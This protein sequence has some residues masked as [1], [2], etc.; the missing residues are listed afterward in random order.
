MFKKILYPT[1]FSDVA[2]EAV[3]YID[4]LRDRD[5]QEVFI[6]HAIDSRILDLL[7]YNPMVSMEMERNLREDA[8]RSMDPLRIHFEEIGFLVS[9]GIEV[10]IPASVILRAE[11]RED[12]SIT[13]MGSH[14]KS[15]VREM[16]LGSVSEEVVRSSRKPVLI[17]KR[18]SR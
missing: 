6:I 9:L 7:V 8:Q 13:V 11:E 18:A 4:Q 2:Q 10:G 12:A 14:G 17:V 5:R 15:N 1:D 3:R 16:I